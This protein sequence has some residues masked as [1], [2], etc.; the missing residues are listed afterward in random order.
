[1]V[2]SLLTGILL[3]MQT[4][5]AHNWFHLRDSQVC[6][7]L[8]IHR[9]VSSC[10]CTGWFY[11]RDTQV[12]FILEIH[13]SVSLR[14]SQVGF[15]L[16]MYRLVSSQRFTGWFHLRDSQVRFISEI[17]RLVS[18]FQN[19][20]FIKLLFSRAG[21]D[22]FSICLSYLTETGGS[23]MRSPTIYTPIHSQI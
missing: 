22:T 6:F 23:V 1:M 12:G 17:H 9:L 5:C 7:I 14:Y 10:R 3:G 16:E 18:S 11:L 2:L 15:I 21:E 4:S 13:R 19:F 20:S 8:E